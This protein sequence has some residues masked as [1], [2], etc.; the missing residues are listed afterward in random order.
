MKAVCTFGLLLASFA[1]V[2][3]AE[4]HGTYVGPTSFSYTTLGCCGESRTSVKITKKKR[5]YI[6]P[7]SPPYTR[8]LA[9]GYHW[10]KTVSTSCVDRYHRGY[11]ARRCDTW[12]TDCRW[13][14]VRVTPHYAKCEEHPNKDESCHSTAQNQHIFYEVDNEREIVDGVHTWYDYYY[15]VEREQDC[16]ESYLVP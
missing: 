1:V 4:A 8:E 9:P 12:K 15:Q 10:H 3:Q 16:S 13:E 2:E 14:D 6:D 11:N 7:L 5:F